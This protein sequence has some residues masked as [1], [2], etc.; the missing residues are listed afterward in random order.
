MTTE[1]HI[2]AHDEGEIIKA[3]HGIDDA[4]YNFRIIEQSTYI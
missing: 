3:I 4:I 1:A 2:V